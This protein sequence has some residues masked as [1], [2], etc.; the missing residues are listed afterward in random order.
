MIAVVDYGA[1]NLKS[2]K[3]ALDYLGAANMRAATAKEVFLADAVILPGVGE[4]GAAMAEIERR[5][6]KEALVAAACGG[7]PFLGIC[8]GMQLLFDES[9]ESPEARGLGLL[10]G[11]V[12]GFS[13]KMGLKI[14]HM[15]WNS[16]TAAKK[17]RLLAGLPSGPYMYFV[18]SYHVAAANRHHVSA[19]AEYGETFDAAVEDENIFGCQFHPEKSGE[20]GLSILKNFIEIINGGR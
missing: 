7:R 10:P 18:H 5:G 14:P 6:L 4:F 20:A 3:N 19:T 13:N 2:V 1:G 15:G 11:S 9:G 16:I 12:P 8:L 17:S